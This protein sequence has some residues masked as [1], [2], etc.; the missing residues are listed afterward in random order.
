MK[1]SKLKINGFGN[2]ENKEINL[3]SG[4][5]LITGNNEKGK[6][7]LLKFILSM[8]YGIPKNKQEKYNPWYAKEFSRKDRI[9]IR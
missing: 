5:N 4:I 8:L 2:L 3:N 6:S 9:Y 7:T 1:I